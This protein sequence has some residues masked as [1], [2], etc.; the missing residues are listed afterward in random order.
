M[1]YLQPM[2]LFFGLVAAVLGIYFVDTPPFTHIAAIAVVV[3]TGFGVV[4][5]LQGE[6]EAAFVRGTL[7]Q[8]ARSVPPSPWW[9]DKANSIVQR[10]ARSKGYLF[11][12]IVYDRPDF[13]DPKANS[14]FLFKSPTSEGGLMN[15]LLV[16][17]PADYSELSLLRKDELETAVNSLLF[18]KRTEDS[19]EA[20]A[21]R[22]GE[23]AAALYAVP[24][25]DQGF[26]VAIQPHD[27]SK[28]LEIKVGQVR[29]S[30]DSTAVQALLKQP[31]VLRN[32]SIAHEIAKAD[33]NLFRYL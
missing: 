1:N 21:K 7:A 25:V 31:P 18:E 4:Q 11:E 32:L 20:F 6:R 28:P 22:L 12:K 10:V 14:I 16:L 24:R 30:Y 33:V 9:K 2:T 17:T 5:A 13:H 27:S 26:Q 3:A 19:A 23:V 8:L 29:L 15:G